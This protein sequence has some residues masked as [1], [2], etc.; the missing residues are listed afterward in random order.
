[1]AMALV[2]GMI[3]STLMTL[4]LVPVGCLV[5][6]DIKR[7]LRGLVGANRLPSASAE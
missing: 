6:D 2:F 7:F 3:S 4:I 1:M 5:L